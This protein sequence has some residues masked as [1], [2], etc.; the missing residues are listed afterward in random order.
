MNKISCILTV[1]WQPVID[2]KLRVKFK[3]CIYNYHTANLMGIQLDQL[4]LKEV[5]KSIHEW[6]E[7]DPEKY[8]EA[9]ENVEEIREQ[10]NEKE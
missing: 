3:L 10:E 9:D 8:V 5:L 7:H 4:A 2:I 1:V 6:H